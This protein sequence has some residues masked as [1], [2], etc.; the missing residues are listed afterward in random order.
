MGAVCGG[1]GRDGV[2]VDDWMSLA[3]LFADSQC[4]VRKPVSQLRDDAAEVAEVTGKERAELTGKPYIAPTCR[5]HGT[6][7]KRPP[8]LEAFL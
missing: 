7:R 3:F 5:K 2:A 8:S 4:I 1:W 6:K